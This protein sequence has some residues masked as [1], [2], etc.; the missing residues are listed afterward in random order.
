MRAVIAIDSLKG[1]L[2]SIEAGQA[3]AEGI[4]FC[5]LTT[6]A[7]QDAAC[8]IHFYT[9]SIACFLLCIYVIKNNFLVY[10]WYKLL[11]ILFCD[12]IGVNNPSQWQVP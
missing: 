9:E 10:I 7:S 6:S 8:R 3:I 5:P 12:K 1:S 11:F 4:I 2:S